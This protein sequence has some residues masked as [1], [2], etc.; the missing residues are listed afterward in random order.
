MDHEA[1]FPGRSQPRAATSVAMQTR[2]PPV[3]QGLQGRA[4]LLWREL[5]RERHDR[6]AAVAE[7]RVQVPD[8]LAGVCRRRGRRA[9]SK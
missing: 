2:A 8:R 3:P 5:P 4:R 6:E 7:A 1:E 9:S